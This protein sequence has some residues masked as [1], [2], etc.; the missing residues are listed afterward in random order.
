MEPILAQLLSVPLGA[1][2]QHRHASTCA[3]VHTRP[4]SLHL[5]SSR[6]RQDFLIPSA[7]KILQQ[8]LSLHLHLCVPNALCI[9]ANICDGNGARSCFFPVRGCRIRITRGGS[10]GQK[11][12]EGSRPGW[13]ERQ[14]SAVITEHRGAFVSPWKIPSQQ[15][16]WWFYCWSG[17]ETRKIID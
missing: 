4:S 15:Y 12:A 9:N 8:M 11:S 7:L 10:R 3:H 6:R 1:A 16:L 2:V 5:Q 17:M 14:S 13:L